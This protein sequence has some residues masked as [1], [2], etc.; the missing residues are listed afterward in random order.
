MY[1]E[2]TVKVQEFKRNSLFWFIYKSNLRNPSSLCSVMGFRAVWS[3]ESKRL[4]LSCLLFMGKASEAWMRSPVTWLS[5][6]QHS[7]MLHASSLS[8][9]L[10]TL[11]SHLNPCRLPK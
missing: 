7:I 6:P 5:E 2:I 11:R 10:S 9:T 3:Q 8:P 1:I 4:V